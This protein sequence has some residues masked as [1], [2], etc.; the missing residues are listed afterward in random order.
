[1]ADQLAAHYRQH[2]AG[3][4]HV[5]Q[6]PVGQLGQDKIRQRAGEF[7]DHVE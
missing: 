3:G 7:G 1:V 4:D 6:G 2:A 5:S